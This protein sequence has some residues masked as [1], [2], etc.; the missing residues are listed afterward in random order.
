MHTG[1]MCQTITLVLDRMSINECD[2]LL[3]IHYLTIACLAIF[4]YHYNRLL[5]TLVYLKIALTVLT[6]NFILQCSPF[7]Y[8]GPTLLVIF[9]LHSLGSLVPF[10]Y[11]AL[12]N[13][14][15]VSLAFSQSV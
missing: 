12:H 11:L 2:R 3:F 10:V 15:R 6:G 1:L 14:P 8:P 4:G 5:S 7:R 13:Q 9:I